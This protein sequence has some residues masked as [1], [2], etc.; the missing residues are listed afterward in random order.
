MNLRNLHWFDTADPGTFF[1]RCYSLT[2]EDERQAFIGQIFSSFFSLHSS[3]HQQCKSFSLHCM[4]SKVAHG[5]FVLSLSSLEDFRRTA[6]TSLLRLIVERDQ[7]LHSRIISHK[8]ASSICFYFVTRFC[9][10]SEGFY[11]NLL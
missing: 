9:V 10:F 7:D 4:G 11:A 3:T 1:P 8:F 2:E 6:C 5:D